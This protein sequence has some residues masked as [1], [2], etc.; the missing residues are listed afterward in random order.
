MPSALALRMTSA[1]VVEMSIN[2]MLMSIS[3]G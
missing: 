1:Q 3:T 2:V